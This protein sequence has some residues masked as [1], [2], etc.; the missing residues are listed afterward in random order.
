MSQLLPFEERAEAVLACVFWGIHHAPDI[1]KYPDPDVPQ[2]EVNAPG[3][4]STFDFDGLTRLVI[5]AHDQCIRATICQGGPRCVKIMLHDRKGRE[6][7]MTHRHPTME[8]AIAGIRGGKYNPGGTPEAK[9]S[10]PP[11]S[12]DAEAGKG[13]PQ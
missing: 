13:G 7:N 2:W 8:E 3:Q 1:K 12:P 9:P 4:L 5:A 10:L 11:P 6:G